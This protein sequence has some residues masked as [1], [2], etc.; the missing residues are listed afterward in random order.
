MEDYKRIAIKVK[1]M[2]RENEEI[3]KR[4]EIIL[5]L[6]DAQ[7]KNLKNLANVLRDV[8]ASKLLFSNLKLDNSKAYIKG[9]GLD[10]DFLALYLQNLEN[11]KE[12]IKALNLKTAQQKTIGDLKLIE[13]ELEVS[14]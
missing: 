3:K 5:T 4:I 7:G 1:E 12:V 8:P 13:F 6:R 14:F 11:N 2:E 9:I 10:M